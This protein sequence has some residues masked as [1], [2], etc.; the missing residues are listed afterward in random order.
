MNSRKKLPE[1]FFW[2]CCWAS[3]KDD[4]LCPGVAITGIIQ[5][6]QQELEA[7]ARKYSI[8]PQYAKITTFSDNQQLRFTA[9]GQNFY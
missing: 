8:H 9:K 3:I 2:D 1:R 7:D 6:R 5:I 4:F